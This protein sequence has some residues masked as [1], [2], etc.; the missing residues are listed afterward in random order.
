VET[1]GLYAT[2]AASAFLAATIL[3]FPSEATFTGLIWSGRVNPWALLAVAGLFNTLGSAVNWWIGKL[4]AD[5]GLQRLPARLRPDP[6]TLAKAEG[7]FGRYGWPSLF[8]SWLPGVGD[9]ATLAAGALRFPF[10]PF[11]LIVGAGKTLRYAAIWAGWS[12][13]AG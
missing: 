9:L 3:P 12:A 4:I 1:L 8:V 6:A 2:M 5:G 7:F 11:L 10:L 13:V